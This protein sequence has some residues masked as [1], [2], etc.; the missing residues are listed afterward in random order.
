M[1]RIFITG[2]SSM[3]SVVVARLLELASHP[4]PAMPVIVVDGSSERS[5]LTDGVERLQKALDQSAEQTK[6]YGAGA[7]SESFGFP[8]WEIKCRELPSSFLGVSQKSDPQAFKERLKQSRH[9]TAQK[10][11]S[12]SAKAR[13][14]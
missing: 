12:L 2:I 5:A 10:Q 3:S 4:I 13:R 9:Q 1:T 7:G 6:F 8:A 11:L 14:R